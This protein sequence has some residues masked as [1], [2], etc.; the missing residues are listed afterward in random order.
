MTTPDEQLALAI[1]D[2]P[3]TVISA[4]RRSDVPAYHTP[5]LMQR[6]R[7]GRVDVRNPFGGNVRRVDL[8]PE[9]VLALQLWTRDPRP[10]LPHLDELTQRGHPLLFHVTLT[11]YPAFLEPG[12]PPRDAVV[13]ALGELRARLGPDAIVWR[14]DPVILADGLEPDGHLARIGDL[15]RR[16]AGIT[17]ECITSWVDR[18]RKTERHLAPALAAVGSSPWPDD[19]ARD[20]ALVGEMAARTAEHGIQLSL[21]CEPDL[22]QPGVPAASCVDPARLSRLLGRTVTLARRP[23]RPGCGCY[24]SIDIGAYDTCPRGCVY[25]YANRSPEAGRRGAAAFGD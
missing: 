11:G 3:P 21:C 8:R 1:G 12:A 20:R 18:Y 17:D 16:L 5:W 25:C 9:A 24:A 6:L 10:L 22:V 19:G 23:T 15:A 7:E 13:A 14:Y 2:P 4:S